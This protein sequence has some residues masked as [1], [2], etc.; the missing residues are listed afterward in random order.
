MS[1]LRHIIEVEK[2]EL[3]K[4]ALIHRSYVNE[5]KGITHNERLEFLGDAVLALIVARYLYVT[6]PDEREGVLSKYSA[7]LV[8]EES[9]AEVAQEI[10]LDGNICVGNGCEVS[11]SVLADTVEALIGAVYL[12]KGYAS[13]TACVHFHILPRLK[14]IIEDTSWMDSKT[15]LNEKTQAKGYDVPHYKTICKD[16]GTSGQIFIS[17]A[18]V[19]H[20]E[21]GVGNGQSKKEAEQG[22]ATEALKTL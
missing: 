22:A 21:V 11:R 20:K 10:G 17:T 15:L 18:V 13:A 8:R 16:E 3:I 5:H 19:N 2:S 4:T 1:D 9:L 12:E 7:A 14:K 6:Y